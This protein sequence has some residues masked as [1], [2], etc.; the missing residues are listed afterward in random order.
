MTFNGAL[1]DDDQPRQLP[2][3]SPTGSG[4]A[5]IALFWADH[6]ANHEFP[7]NKV[8]YGFVPEDRLEVHDIFLHFCD[9]CSKGVETQWA[10]AITWEEV[11]P[12]S[13]MGKFLPCAAD[14]IEDFEAC[15]DTCYVS[16]ASFEECIDCPT[17]EE[18]NTRCSDKYE[19]ICWHTNHRDIYYCAVDCEPWDDDC[20]DACEREY[21]GKTILRKLT[22]HVCLSLKTRGG[23]KLLITM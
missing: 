21:W 9:N 20:F 15:T 3:S 18:Y 5:M 1:A 23:I 17:I 7:N 6:R 2:F 19:R 10:L 13:Q 22:S 12:A 14:Y 8:L 4:D 16:D 11:Q